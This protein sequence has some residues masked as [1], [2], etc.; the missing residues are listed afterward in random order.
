VDF[1]GEEREKQTHGRRD[2]RERREKK[3]KTRDKLAA[4]Q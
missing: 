3:I 2:R 4:Q 1:A